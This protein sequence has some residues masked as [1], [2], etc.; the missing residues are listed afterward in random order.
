M[1]DTKRTPVMKGFWY[2]DDYQ[3]DSTLYTDQLGWT[4]EQKVESGGYTKTKDVWDHLIG[5]SGGK[6]V[7]WD[8]C[9]FYAPNQTFYYLDQMARVI[10]KLPLSGVEKEPLFARVDI[11]PQIVPEEDEVFD[12]EKISQVWDDFTIDGHHMDY[13]LEHSVLVLST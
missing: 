12:Y 2:V 1:R 10:Y 3:K 13:I 9:F 5:F 6:V 7:G 8:L 4:D 11:E